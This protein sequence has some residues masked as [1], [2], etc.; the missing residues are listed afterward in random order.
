MRNC[1]ILKFR[2]EDN[3]LSLIEVLKQISKRL[4]ELNQTLILIKDKM[5]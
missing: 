2:E 5:Q 1:P 3:M 4:Y